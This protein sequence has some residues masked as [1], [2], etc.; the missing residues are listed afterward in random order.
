MVKLRFYHGT[1]SE[2]YKKILKR[3]FV[4]SKPDLADD[5]DEHNKSN[6]SFWLAPVGF[7]L[8]CNRPLLAYKYAKKRTKRDQYKC[9][10]AGKDTVVKPVVFEIKLKNFPS[11]GIFDLTTDYGIL[12]L[13][14]AHEDI[15]FRMEDTKYIDASDD[16]VKSIEDAKKKYGNSF[17]Y[18]SAAIKALMEDCVYKLIIA[19]IQEGPTF[20]YKV[21]GHELKYDRVEGFHGIRLRDHLE[22][23]VVDIGILNKK[24]MSLV[25]LDT[26]ENEYNDI[27]H[28]TLTDMHDSK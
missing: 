1:S 15:K 2:G 26:L 7:Y 14:K 23:C 25:C 8:F 22:A 27:L 21:H 19:A 9:R 20:N 28:D 6:E 24:S 4:Y 16:Y 17:N 12:K 18:D 11:D 13:N 3:G 5:D 10:K